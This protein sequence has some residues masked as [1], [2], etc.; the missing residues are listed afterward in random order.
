MKKKIVYEQPLNERMRNILRL[1]YLF[2]YI[3]YCLKGPAEWDS[4]AVINCIVEVL[5]FIDRIDF[6]AELIK[7]LNQHTQTLE[8]WQSTTNVNTEHLDKLLNKTRTVIN[9]LGE[10]EEPLGESLSQHQLIRLVRQRS[11][12]SGGAC[13]SDLPGY[14]HWLQKNP[15]QRQNE[16]SDWLAPLNPLRDAT[17]LD[18]YLIR[19]N[20]VISQEIATKGFFQSKLDANAQSQIIQVMMPGEH[21]CY[22]KIQA[23]KQRFTIRFFEQPHVE[24]QAEPTEQNINFKLCCCMI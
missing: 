17:D 18:L 20:A 12:I 8:Y 3:S 15:K 6:K 7:D 21:P 5:N 24:E 10:L 19:N 1:E 22:P 11:N 14:Y 4:R 2:A 16:L 13:R 23:G 9:K